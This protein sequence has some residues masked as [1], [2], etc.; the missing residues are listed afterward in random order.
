MIYIFET[1]KQYFLS[2]SSVGQISYMRHPYGIH[3]KVI[4]IIG[5]LKST[6]TKWIALTELLFTAFLKIVRLP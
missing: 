5:G 2:A 1:K 3:F 6:D 4:V